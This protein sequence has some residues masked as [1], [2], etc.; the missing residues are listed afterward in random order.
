MEEQS[1]LLLRL[2]RPSVMNRLARYVEFVV[3]EGGVV[4]VYVRSTRFVVRLR[5]SFV[6]GARDGTLF[7]VFVPIHPLRPQAVPYT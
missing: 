2:N 4:L 1:V 6:S 5:V 3:R 7:K